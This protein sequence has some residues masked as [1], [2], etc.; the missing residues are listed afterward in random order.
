[1]DSHEYLAKNLLELAEI[2][3]DP[4]VKLSA[5]LD[6]LE[7]Y[8]LFKF[9]LKDS[10][11]D[12]R[13]LIIENMKKSDSKIYELYSE[14]IDEMFNYLISGKCNE[15]LVKRVKELISQKVSS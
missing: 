7:E 12:Y 11:V 8:A 13:Y 5:L 4:V 1:M 15:E 9:Q 6:C 14:V 3:R 2:S 10:I